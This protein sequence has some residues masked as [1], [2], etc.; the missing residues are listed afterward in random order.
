MWENF[1]GAKITNEL[2]LMQH[3]IGNMLQMHTSDQY[4]INCFEGAQPLIYE[5]KQHLRLCAHNKL[6]FAN[7][8]I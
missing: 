8:W 2:A 4:P 3:S 1:G 6:L 5:L 7:V